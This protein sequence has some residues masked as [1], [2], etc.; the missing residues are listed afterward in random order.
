[1]LSKQY[2]NYVIYFFV[3]HSLEALCKL[4]FSILFQLLYQSISNSEIKLSYFYAIVAGFIFFI[5]HISRNNGFYDINFFSG[6]I[7]N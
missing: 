1:M 2:G 3:M 4:G 7:K 5:G 6:R